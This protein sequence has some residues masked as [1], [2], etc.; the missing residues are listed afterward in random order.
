MK[1]SPLARI[2]AEPETDAALGDSGGT[3]AP[4]TPGT[5]SQ[6]DAR[7]P[8]GNPAEDADPEL[9]GNAGQGSQDQ[10]GDGAVDTAAGSGPGPADDNPESPDP[11][12]AETTA[13]PQPRRDSLPGQFGGGTGEYAGAPRAAVDGGEPAEPAANAAPPDS[14]QDPN[15]V[16]EDDQAHKRSGGPGRP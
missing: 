4:T 6:D 2:F 16:E 3:A 8:D 13:P 14:A 7:V 1:K 9:Q 12:H 5:E 11:P 15:R 10:S